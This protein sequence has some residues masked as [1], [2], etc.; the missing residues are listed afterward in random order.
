MP[1]NSRHHS[2]ESLRKEK[3]SVS[4][5]TGQKFISRTKR[6][7]LKHLP[8]L[9]GS[10]FVTLAILFF[11]F[12]YNFAWPYLGAFNILFKG[13]GNVISFVSGSRPK[14]KSSNQ[15]INILFLGIGGGSHE[16]PLL[17][18]S[19][20][21]LSLPYGENSTDTTKGEVLVMSVPRDIWLDSLGYRI[22]EAYRIGEEKRKGGGLILAKAAISEI[23]DQPIHYSVRVDFAG[24]EKAIDLLG[25]IEVKVE[26]A[27]DDYEYPIQGKELDD[28]SGDPFYRCR[29]EHLRFDSGP[30][31]MSGNQALKFA[32][33]RHAEGPEGSDY[34]RAKRQQKI[35]QAVKA[36]VLTLNTLLNA[37]KVRELSKTFAENLDTDIKDEEFDDF[38]KLGLSLK[39]ARIKTIFLDQGDSE[40]GRAGLLTEGNS[41]NY[42]GAWV[43]V[44]KNGNWKEAQKYISEN[45]FDGGKD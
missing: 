16:G 11:F 10:F 39:E 30:Q 13:P 45:F 4:L 25:G 9:K 34:A 33:S 27:F 14:L 22:N 1:Q 44:P 3:N 37:S 19:M 15:R 41:Q 36:K 2:A 7:A 17:T 26:N 20:M 29:Y 35:F 28:C 42:G 21:L 38:L 23:I 31:V 12:L 32:R 5:T 40:N 24:F 6:R 8:I 43:L 18:D